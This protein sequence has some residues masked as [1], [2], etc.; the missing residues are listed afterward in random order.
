MSIY[1]LP[2]EMR[3]H[4]SLGTPEPMSVFRNQLFRQ[5]HNIQD[6]VTL[7][8]DEVIITILLKFK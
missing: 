2:S 4:G 1:L 7:Y 3:K 8:G 6:T 5:G